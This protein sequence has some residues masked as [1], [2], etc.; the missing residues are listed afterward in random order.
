MCKFLDTNLAAFLPTQ[1][2]DP[3]ADVRVMLSIYFQSYEENYIY[4]RY[5]DQFE[6]EIDRDR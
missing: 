6:S 3:A 4:R 2:S 5:D 1:P